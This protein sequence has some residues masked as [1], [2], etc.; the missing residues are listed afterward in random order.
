MPNGSLITFRR[1]PL[2][3]WIPVCQNLAAFEIRSPNELALIPRSDIRVMFTDRLKN[4]LFSLRQAAHLGCNTVSPDR[5]A[6]FSLE[7]WPDASS[8]APPFRCREIG[9]TSAA[10]AA[11]SA[12]TDLEL[13]I[14]FEQAAPPSQILLI[15]RSERDRPSLIRLL[16]TGDRPNTL[17]RAPDSLRSVASGVQCRASFC[18]LINPLLSAHVWKCSSSDRI[19][20]SGPNVRL[21]YFSLIEGLSTSAD[22]S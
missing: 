3:D 6:P 9:Q 8:L 17:R 13:P 10:L 18:D 5:V 22:S 4:L 21:I 19:I 11:R 20:Q 2:E 16:I 15:E 7:R 12:Q 1:N 14:N